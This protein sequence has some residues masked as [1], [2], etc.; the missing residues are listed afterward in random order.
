[1]AH[2]TDH[3]G[4]KHQLHKLTPSEVYHIRGLIAEGVFHDEIA[5]RFGIHKSTVSKIATRNSWAW[6]KEAA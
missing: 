2:G 4:E 3:R 1:V 6:L 5:P